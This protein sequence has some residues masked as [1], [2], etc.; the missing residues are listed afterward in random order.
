MEYRGDL[1]VRN[2]RMTVL[3]YLGDSLQR[4]VPVA[5]D[6][7]GAIRLEGRPVT[8]GLARDLDTHLCPLEFSVL[9]VC[10]PIEPS[11]SDVIGISEL[12]AVEATETSVV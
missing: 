2:L 5:M 1:W 8:E 9:Y 6:I 3:G 7:V 4:A 11:R 10:V 12:I